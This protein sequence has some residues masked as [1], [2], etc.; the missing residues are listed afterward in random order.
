METFF[1]SQMEVECQISVYCG[2]F[3]MPWN[4]A[5]AVTKF[6]S[7]QW[8]WVVEYWNYCVFLNAEVGCMNICAQKQ[9]VVSSFW[10][11]VM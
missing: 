2:S 3:S 7:L 1:F 11:F 6:F 8:K 5:E 4:V 10:S 9:T